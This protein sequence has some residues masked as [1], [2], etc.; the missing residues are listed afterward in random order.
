MGGVAKG[1]LA[2]PD[3]RPIVTRTRELFGRMGVECVL[4]G[5]G[6]S[7]DAL[8]LP[9]LPDAYEGIGPLG[10][11]IALLRHA[12]EGDAVVA[13]CDMPHLQEGIVR[14][15]LDAPPCTAIAPKMAG[16]WQPMLARFDAKAALPIAVARA[17]AKRGSLQRLLDELG[18]QELAL[19]SNEERSLADWDTPMDR[20]TT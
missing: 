9:R 4:L 20:G 5:S 12:G 18:A 13:A 8:G 6:R 2:S 15:L 19:S 16:V 1:L 17:E 10:G 3:G 11:L 7:Y 14:R